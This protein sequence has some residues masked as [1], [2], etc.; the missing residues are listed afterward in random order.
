[1]FLGINNLYIKL[2]IWH[3]KEHLS[4]KQIVLVTLLLSLPV[5]DLKQKNCDLYSDKVISCIKG[6]KDA[7][8]ILEGENLIFLV[9][10]LLLISL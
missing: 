7:Q 10:E 6:Q 5:F 3:P 2:S 1:M 8:K 9:T 4:Y